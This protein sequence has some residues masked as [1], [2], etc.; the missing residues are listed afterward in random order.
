MSFI[1]AAP[2]L[3]TT[4]AADVC[5]LADGISQATRAAAAPT[6]TVLAAGAD[7]VSAAVAALFGAHGQAYQTT[8]TR[9]AVFHDQLVNTLSASAGRY[10]RAEAAGAVTLQT[11]EQNLLGAFN[12]P[13]QLL[14][15]RP[16]I[17]NGGDG[18]RYRPKRW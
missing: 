13:T 16:L 14:L 5:R 18:A 8:S 3:I 11:L 2:Q 6:S 17:G 15:G 12:T 7:E 1:S 4:A 9:A 10:A